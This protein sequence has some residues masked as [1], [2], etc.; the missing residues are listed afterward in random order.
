ML[1][2]KDDSAKSSDGDE[3]MEDGGEMTMDVF[4]ADDTNLFPVLPVRKLGLQFLNMADYLQRNY[5]LLRLEA[6]HD[7]GGDLETP[8]EQL[9]AVRALR[10]SSENDTIFRGFSR[11]AVPLASALQIV[12]VGKLALG[13]A[14]PASVAAHVEVE[15]YGRHERKVFDRYQTKEVVFLVAVRAT[16]DEGAE[17]MGFQKQEKD[18]G[19]FPEHF[20][21]QY[22]RAAE[23]IEVTDAAGTAVNDENPVGKASK[24][25]FKLALDGVQYNNDLETGHLDAYEQVNLLVRRNPRENNF[26]A[27][28]DTVA[29]AW[30]DANKE[31]LLPT[32]LYDLVLSYGNPVAAQYT[33]IYLAK[34]E[35]QVSV[36]LGGLL[37]DGKHVLEAGGT[38]KLV[39]AGND[40][41]A[42]NAKDAVAPF[43][44]VEDLRDGTSFICAHSTKKASTE[45]PSVRPSIRL[46]KAQVAA[47]RTGAYEGLKLVVGPPG[48]DKTG[49]AVPLVLNLYRT[50]PAREK[51]LI[52][53]HSNQALNDFF[54]KIL[55]QNAIHEPEIVRMGQPQLDGAGGKK[56]DAASHMDFSRHGRVAFLL[57]RRAALLAEV[58]QMAQWLIKRDA[59]R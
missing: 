23:I 42:L 36:P 6:A 24:R 52:V 25:T 34:A 43:T 57:E 28:L 29:G 19:S 54:A 32:W 12:K 41:Q 47:V 45:Q 58:E 8:I 18:T 39:D 21:V 2:R 48:T 14:A 20:G 37:L 51:I 26:K 3:P 40:G 7:I 16:A 15:L 59:L 55:A 44:Y 13:Q 17:L 11:S 22:V 5:E 56:G 35:K 27:V 10:S 50:T 46:T 4:A 49:V 33:S 30:D 31:E 1:D 9:D 53:A 38:E